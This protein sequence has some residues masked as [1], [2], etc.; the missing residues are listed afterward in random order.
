AQ[1]IALRSARGDTRTGAASCQR[2]QFHKM[3]AARP[4][5]TAYQAASHGPGTWRYSTAASTLA[6]AIEGTLLTGACRTCSASRKR[7]VS[8]AA[9]FGSAALSGVVGSSTPSFPLRQLSVASTGGAGRTKTWLG[10]HPETTFSWAVSR[11]G[12]VKT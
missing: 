5:T 1:R 3:A 8:S 4:Q 2:R 12:A 9:E 10:S 7:A 11:V 6:T